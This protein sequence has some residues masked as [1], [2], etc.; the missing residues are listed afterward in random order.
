MT[1]SIVGYKGKKK[2]QRYSEAS[3]KFK[4]DAM[5][6]KRQETSYLAMTT[7]S[8]NKKRPSGTRAETFDITFG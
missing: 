8:F 7:N 1:N 6:E 2:N 3:N 4:E 5:A